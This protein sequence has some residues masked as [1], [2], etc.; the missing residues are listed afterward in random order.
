MEILKDTETIFSIRVTECIAAE[1]YLPCKAGD[2]GYAA[3]CWGD[4]T[5]AAE[6]K[7]K[8]Q[9]IRDKTLMQGHDHCNHQY[10][11]TG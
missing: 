4:Y 11:W 9:L 3:V 8:I 1:S 6:F 10:I 5:W 2:I 7:P